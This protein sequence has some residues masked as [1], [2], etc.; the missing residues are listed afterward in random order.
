MCT[1]DRGHA[2]LSASTSRTRRVTSDEVV[3]DI[4]D[5][6]GQLRSAGLVTG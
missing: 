2:S 6:V 3:K 1:T 5:F 4:D